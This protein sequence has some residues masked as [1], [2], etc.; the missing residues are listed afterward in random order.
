[1]A[2]KDIWVRHFKRDPGDDEDSVATNEFKKE[3]FTDYFG[4][5]LQQG[6]NSTIDTFD[7]LVTVFWSKHRAP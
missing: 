2:T 3:N 1:M 5:F 4:Q 6:T 7:K